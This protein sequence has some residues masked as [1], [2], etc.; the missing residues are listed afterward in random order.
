MDI[1]ELE[2]FTDLCN[3]LYSLENDLSGLAVSL[4]EE[5]YSDGEPF[6]KMIINNIWSICHQTEAIHKILETFKE[7]LDRKYWHEWVKKHPHI[8]KDYDEHQNSVDSLK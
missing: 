5:G 7:S 1:K 4:D 6:E 3:L 8:N 2:T